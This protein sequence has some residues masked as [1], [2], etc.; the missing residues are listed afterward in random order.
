MQ[1]ES[2]FQSDLN[3]RTL[4]NDNSSRFGKFI[5]M[6]FRLEK[7][8]DKGGTIG[9]L[10]GA[11][12]H[13][14]LL[15][16]VR[17]CRQLQNERNYHAFYQLAS[18]KKNDLLDEQGIFTITCERASQDFGVIIGEP[19]NYL[20][21]FIDADISSLRYINMSK[22]SEL[23]GVVDSDEFQ[24][25][26]LAMNTVGISH[27]EQQEIWNLVGAVLYLGNINF[28]E[29]SDGESA[30]IRVESQTYLE[31]TSKLLGVSTGM[32]EYC[33][34]SRTIIVQDEVFTKPLRV[35]QAEDTRDAMARAL[36]GTMFSRIVEQTNKS[37]GCQP[38]EKL[39]CG[40]LDIF[41]FECFDT[42]SLEQLCI[43]FANERLQYFFNKFIFECEEKLYSDEGIMWEPLDFPGKCVR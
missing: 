17:V 43:N 14:Y 24:R 3:S 36:Y 1:S 21:D 25:T 38:D 35:P 5:E 6:Q 19:I 12:I 15:E 20:F 7:N 9:R 29:S 28:I 26:A 40:V 41:G 33:L 42:N 39:S 4:R 34:C 30:K 8:R 16:T 32:L 2:G 11:S 37:I 18:L 23:K 31:K 27:A 22:C 10:T 13:T